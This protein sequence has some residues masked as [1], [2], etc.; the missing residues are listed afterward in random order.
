MKYEQTIPVLILV[1][2]LLGFVQIAG[3][4]CGA[5]LLA[6]TGPSDPAIFIIVLTMIVTIFSRMYFARDYEHATKI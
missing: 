4:T 2:L 5:I 3:A 6:R 1:R